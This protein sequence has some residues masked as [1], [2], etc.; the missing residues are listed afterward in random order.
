MRSLIRTLA[1]RVLERTSL[2]TTPVGEDYQVRVK[3]LDNVVRDCIGVSQSCAGIRAP[4]RA[5]FYASLLFT[6]MCTRAATLAVLVPKSPFCWKEF[7]QWDYSSAAAL[8]RSLLELRVAFFYLCTENVE[9]EE[10]ECRWNLF[11]L[12]DCTSRFNLF[13]EM[14]NLQED[15]AGFTEQQRELRGRLTANSH[16]ISLTPGEQKKLLHGQTAYLNPLEKIA[17]RAGVELATF[18]LIYRLFSSQVHGFPLAYYRMAEQNRGRG[19][20]SESEEGYTALC[21]SLALTL[22]TR[23]RDEMRSLFADAR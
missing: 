8:T 1:L 7:E 18:R 15:L 10:W 5:H 22:L 4:T 23:S 14:P 6:A 3:A 20:H 19:V 17:V 21:V 16:F 11:N 12:H 2:R 9:Q 13:L